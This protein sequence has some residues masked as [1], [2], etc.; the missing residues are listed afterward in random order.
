MSA[1]LARGL[2]PS[3]AS[4]QTLMGH[5]KRFANLAAQLA[6]KGFSLYPLACGGYLIARHDRSS[7]APD[8]RAVDGFLE[9]MAR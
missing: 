5:D 2:G 9:A 8:L 7:Y 3:P 6:L 1:D 4:A